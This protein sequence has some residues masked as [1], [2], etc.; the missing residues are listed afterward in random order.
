MDPREEIKS[1]VDLVAFI[2]EFIPLKQ[3][4][5]NFKTNCPFHGEKTPSFVVSPERQIWH[6][7]G[8]GKG[9]DIYAFLMEYERMEFPEALRTLAKRAGVELETNHSSSGLGS[10]KERIYKINRLAK[11]FYHYLLTKHV[12]GKK[13]L[14]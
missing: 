11:E 8:C 9:G 3:M 1:K 10:Q 7:F 13:G 14:E 4:G 12:V 5:R 6:C 2:S